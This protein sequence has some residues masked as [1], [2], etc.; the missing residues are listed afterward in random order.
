MGVRNNEDDQVR[1]EEG[2]VE[3]W[4]DA[5]GGSQNR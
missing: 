4:C 2:R 3:H 1:D 5:L